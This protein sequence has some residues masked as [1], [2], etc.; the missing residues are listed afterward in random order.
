M[1]VEAKKRF[2]HGFLLS[3]P[4]LRRTIEL[5]SEQFRKLEETITPLAVY[6]IKYRNGAVSSTSNL[7][8][9]FNQENLGS[10][11]IIRLKMKFSAEFQ[12]EDISITL[13]YI[14]VDLDEEPGSTSIWY[15][16]SANSRDWVFV[17]SALI[18][19]RIEKIRRRCPN[20]LGSSSK[21]GA[22]VRLL[23]FPLIMLAMIFSM[24]VGIDSNQ[25]KVSEM[26]VQAKNSGQIKDAVDALI[27]I[28]EAKEKQKSAV[29]ADILKPL[30]YMAG[31]II[32]LFSVY[33]FFLRY[34]LVFN[35]LWGD[36]LEEFKKREGVRKFVLVIICIGIVVSFIGGI[37]ANMTGINGST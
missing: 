36:Y 37:L 13:G 3:E 34:Y 32:A 7:D 28:E 30:A 25:D 2:S 22:P 19:E 20:E 17:T 6:E 11:Q 21:R 35:F 23:V 9:V 26:L 24:V 12:G 33:M 10:S 5:I 1:L 16:I 27:I 4:E 15:N 29:G 31:A 14:N 18:Q 8:D